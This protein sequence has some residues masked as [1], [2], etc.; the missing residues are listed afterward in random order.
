MTMESTTPPRAA[1]HGQSLRDLAV[2][3]ATYRWHLALPSLSCLLLATLLAYAMPPSYTAKGLILVE[4]G[5]DPTMRT[6][7]TT[8]TVEINEA[9]ETEIQFITSKSVAATVVDQLGLHLRTPPPSLLRT[10]TSAVMH[11]GEALGLIYPIE[12]REKVIEGFRKTVKAKQPPLTWTILLKFSADNPTD[13]K[14]IL[15]RTI[16]AYLDH[17]RSVYR[18]EAA[19]W[20]RN[21]TTELDNQLSALDTALN[22]TTD[23]TVR[24][25]MELERRALESSYLSTRERLDRAVSQTEGDRSLYNVRVIDRPTLPAQPDQPR[26]LLIVAGLVAGCM[27]GMCGALV[28]SY[29]DRTVR[30]GDDVRAC[31]LEVLATIPDDR[32]LP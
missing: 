1:M 2:F 7:L 16:D 12:R 18:S 4:R 21:R 10:I 29:F 13:A 17:R 22:R 30:N 28:R 8:L 31:G 3:V 5:K 25:R 27:L 24:G 19:T 20:F 14:D 6:E 15:D 23:P 9:I 32:T 26:L 11:S